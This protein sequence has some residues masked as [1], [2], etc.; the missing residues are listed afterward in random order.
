[1]L[2]V[3]VPVGDKPVHVYLI[4]SQI[5]ECI[6]LLNHSVHLSIVPHF[7]GLLFLGY[8]ELELWF[9]LMVYRCAFCFI[10]LRYWRLISV[11]L[12]NF[13]YLTLNKLK[14]LLKEDHLL[15][16]VHFM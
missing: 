12:V 5:R 15:L 4:V 7:S 3:P 14:E 6:P 8:G 10:D 9:L 2:R 1:M 11:C 16:Q 13:K